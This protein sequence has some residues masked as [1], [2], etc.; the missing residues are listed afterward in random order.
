MKTLSFL[1]NYLKNIT[2]K[3]IVKCNP[4]WE[5]NRCYKK[6]FQGKKPNLKDPKNLIEKIYWLELN[7]DTSLW[8]KCT[9]KYRVR[10]YIAECGLIDYMPKLYGKWD[11]VDNINFT[12]LPNEFVLKTNDGC[13]TVYIVHNKEEEDLDKIRVML[14]GWLKQIHYGYSNAQLHYLGI[15]S[16]IIAEELLKQTEKESHISPF[17]LIDYKIWAFRG[18][19][20]CIWVA[21]NR[22]KH[23]VKMH[24]YDLNWNPMPHYLAPNSHYIYDS[25]I[26]IPKPQCLSEMLNMTSILSRNF[27]EVRVD[28]YVVNNRPYIGELTFA[29]GYGYFTE[30]YYKLLGEKVNISTKNKHK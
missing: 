8:T 29:S 15:K 16:C 18:E 11:K 27:P 21:Y 6:T 20:E 25:S 4:T 19:P 3:I 2:K 23:K 24:L 10:E 12:N 22:Q 30:E 28:F 17:S 14:K 7:S 13:G 26:S 1:L 9:D 5:I